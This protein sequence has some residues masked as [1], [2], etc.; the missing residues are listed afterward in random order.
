MGDG[1]SKL[2]IQPKDNRA[3]LNI[4]GQHLIFPVNV[5]LTLIIFILTLGIYGII[6]V[7]EGSETVKGA[8]PCSIPS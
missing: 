1:D 4:L 2:N 8:G 5:Y 7:L 3:D 6:N